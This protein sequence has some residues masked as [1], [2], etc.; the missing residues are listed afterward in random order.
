MVSTQ[1]IKKAD[2]IYDNVTLG[3]TNVVEKAVPTLM[4]PDNAIKIVGGVEVVNDLANPSMPATSKTGILYNMYDNWEDFKN[5]Y[6]NED[7]KN[8]E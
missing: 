1:A 2:G 5:F 7:S 3:I 8:E 4:K 6:F